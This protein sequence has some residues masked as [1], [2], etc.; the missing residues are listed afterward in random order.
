MSDTKDKRCPDCG[1]AM[2]A[3]GQS[4]RSNCGESEVVP[5]R[6][7]LS[8]ARSIDVPAVSAGEARMYEPLWN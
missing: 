5:D 2:H 1:D 7:R 4:E 3:P 6:L 8:S